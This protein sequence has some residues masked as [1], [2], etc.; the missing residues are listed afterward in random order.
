MVRVPL[1][2]LV[3]QIHLLRLGKAGAFL[4]RVLQVNGRLGIELC[5]RSQLAGQ[6]ALSPAHVACHLASLTPLQP[7]LSSAPALHALLQPPPEKSVAGAIRTLQDVGALT[8]AEDLTPLGA[9]PACLPAFLPTCLLAC[10]RLPAADPSL[11]LPACHPALTAPSLASQPRLLCSSLRSRPAGHHLAA[12]P[13]DARIGKLLLLSASLGCLAP[14]L[15]NAACLSY[16][17]PFS[18]GTQQDAADRARAALAAPG[19]GT[20]AAGQQSDHLLMVA[21]VDGWL[22]ARAKGGHKGGRAP[23]VASGRGRGRQ[24]L[25][26]GGV[27]PLPARSVVVCSLHTACLPA[28]PLLSPPSPRPL[29]ALGSTAGATSCLNRRWTC[30]QTCAG[31]MPPCLPTLAS[32]QASLAAGNSRGTHPCTGCHPACSA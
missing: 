28:W 19:S 9:S 32:W 29:Q 20:I 30:W 12:L 15:T 23:A 22:A 24:Q 8:L 18:G 10:C 25:G 27:V 21:A 31:S 11:T 2:E 13:V 7:L 4:A 14:A 6:A 1:E 26:C 16:K 5:G 3:L 17:S